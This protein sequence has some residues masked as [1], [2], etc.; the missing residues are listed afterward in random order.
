MSPRPDCRRCGGEGWVM[1][2]V[3]T[4]RHGTQ[5]A[6]CSCPECC[7]PPQEVLDDW[8]AT[9]RWHPVQA[10]CRHCADWTHLRDDDGHP[11]H[12][13]CAARS[14]HGTRREVGAT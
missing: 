3:L 12:W 7:G 8:R 9:Y 5:S 14:A 6:E 1:V 13:L 10:L 4:L 11:A 2:S